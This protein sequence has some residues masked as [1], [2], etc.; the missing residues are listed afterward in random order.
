[1]TASVLQLDQAGVRWGR[2]QALQG[3]SLQVQ[4]GEC[5]AL[6]GGNGSGKSTLLRLAHGLVLPT[7][8]TV[9]RDGAARQAF[10]FQKP[11]VLRA[12]VLTNVALAA[13]LQ[14]GAQPKPAAWAQA[15]A[16]ALLAL[17]QV[18]L[19]ALATRQART[20]SGGQ[21]QRLTFARALCTQPD[22][23]LLDE[24]TASLAPQAKRDVEVLMHQCSQRGTTLLF[25]SHNLG[26]VKRLATRVVCLDAGRVV[27][28]LPVAEFFNPLSPQRQASPTAVQFLESETL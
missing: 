8:G 16:S 9:Q 6:V 21:Q 5:I 18:D 25:A 19:H 11:Y 28:D 3:V 23:L 4:R 15:K 10:V 17:T 12:T 27:A 7:A 14:T 24:P 1:M 2:V 22:V 13:W 20:L 26:Q